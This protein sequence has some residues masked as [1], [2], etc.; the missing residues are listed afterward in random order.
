MRISVDVGGTFTDV[1]VLDEKTL[2]LRLEKVE[3]TPEN[4]AI[5]VLQSFEKADAKLGEIECFVHGTTLG[6]NSLLTRQLRR[7][8][9]KSVENV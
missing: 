1:I 5:G 2:S 6:I 7:P 3:T 8:Y 9:G 4:P